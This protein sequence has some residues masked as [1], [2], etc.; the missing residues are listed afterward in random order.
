M[1]EIT[2]LIL[3]TALLFAIAAQ[4]GFTQ[5]RARRVGQTAP[6]T[7]PSPRTSGE[8]PKPERTTSSDPRLSTNNSPSGKEG[9][10]VVGEDDVVR[11]NTTLVM[12]PVSI[13][14]RDGR[15]VA[16]LQEG[17]FHIYENGIEQEVVYFASVEKPFTVV[18]MLDT[19]ASTWSKLGQIRGAAAAFIEQLRPDDQVMVVSFARGVRVQCESTSDRQK[20]REAIQQTGKGLSTHL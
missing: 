5:T 7:S 14:D 17:D 2:S 3:I 1:K 19:S 13:T 16:D 9:Q 8:T 18:L 12:V 10:D 20:I 6:G 4:S 11:V 15:Y